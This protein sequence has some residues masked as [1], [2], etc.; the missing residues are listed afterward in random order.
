ML[1]EKYIGLI[2]DYLDGIL[3]QKE[4]DSLEKEL[5]ESA[6]LRDL[7]AIVQLSRESIKLSGQKEMISKIHEE[8]KKG[9]TEET[10][11]ATK[12]S[13][14]PWWIGIAASLTLL[15]LVGNFWI[16]SQADDFFSNHYMAYELPTMRSGESME[17]D[18]ENLYRENDYES[19]IANVD[20]S[21]DVQSELFLA[22]LAHIE[23]KNYDASVRY[24]L[25][26]QELNETKP[27]SEKFFQE[28]TDY[29]L[30]LVLLKTENFE[31]ADI[32]YKRITENKSHAFHQNLNTMDKI[33]Y[34]IIIRKNKN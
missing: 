17:N 14:R 6:E 4:K 26:I 18:V 19:V 28:E 16:N 24:L 32:Y 20:I 30:L 10:G 12:L 21:S 5:N 3:D 31:E 27:E 33:R 7:L 23:L 34:S 15:V 8:F 11:K 2:D 1:D 9:S 13:I 22:G 25:K 29:Y